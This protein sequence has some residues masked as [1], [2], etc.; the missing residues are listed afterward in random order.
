MFRDT[1]VLCFTV[2]SS[3]P[4][5]QQ[6]AIAQARVCCAHIYI[7]F[8][9]YIS[10]RGRSS[11]ARRRSTNRVMCVFH[12]RRKRPGKLEK[13]RRRRTGYYTNN[14]N[15]KILYVQETGTCAH[16]HTHVTHT[17]T[18]L[19]WQERYSEIRRK[20]YGRTSA[21]R[22]RF[23]VKKPINLLLGAAAV[24]KV[25]KTILCSSSSSSSKR[26]STRVSVFRILLARFS[27]SGEKKNVV[28]ITV[29]PVA[30]HY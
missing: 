27:P 9:K 21:R 15:N 5:F 7:Y 22:L 6:N 19:V 29:L 1:Y 23:L 8:I 10:C 16:K 17:H 3:W 13:P 18:P 26:S 25:K 12:K 2:Q 20:L 28:F 30:R 11:R 24:V 4:R 14:N